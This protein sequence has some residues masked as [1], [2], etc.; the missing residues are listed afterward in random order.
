MKSEE[1]KASTGI[2]DHWLV[3]GRQTEQEGDI[4]VQRNW[5]YGLES[6]QFALILNFAYRTQ[7]VD[8]SLVPGTAMEAELVFYPG[9]FPL[10]ALLKERIRTVAFPEVPG[11]TDWQAVANQYAVHS[12]I[13]PWLYQW[14]VI[15]AD[16]TLLPLEKQWLLK[17]TTN[18]VALLDK[19]FEK[20]WKVLAYGGG[21]PLTMC[22]IR[23]NDHFLPLGLWYKERYVAL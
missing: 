10:R 19:K 14:P 8:L 21:H 15:V 18:R 4:T 20:L 16:I 3:L 23:E 7:T 6:R 17:D 12:S 9:N 5:L 1:L 13:S 2:V 22:F 11:L